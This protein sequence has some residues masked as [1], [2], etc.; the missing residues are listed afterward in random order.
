MRDPLLPIVTAWQNKIKLALESKAKRFGK[1]AE[2]GMK[3]FSGPCDWLYGESKGRHFK[4]TFDGDEDGEIPPPSFQMTVNK[5]AELVQ[6]FGPVLYHRNPVRQVNP[7]QHPGPPASLMQQ[8]MQDPMMALQFQ[9]LAAQAQASRAVDEARADLLEHY[10]NYTPTALD[11]KTHARMAIDEALIKGMGT[12]WTEVYQPPGSG[13]RMVGNFYDTVDNLV[14]DP[15]MP[16]LDTCKWIA[17]RRVQPCWEVERRFN[18]PA[19]SIRG[20]YESSGQQGDVGANDGGD[21]MRKTGQ[22]CDLCTY[23][24]VF[25][26]CGIGGRLSGVDPSIKN[27]LEAYGDFCYLAICEDCTYPLNL[28]DAVW[29][30]E[31]SAARSEIMK[32]VAW[33]TPF[34]ADGRWPMVPIYFHTIPGDPWPMSHLAPGLGELKFLNWAYSYV[35]G[36]IRISC[37]DFIAILQEAGAEVVESVQHGADYEII[38]IKGSNGRQI[39]EI[40][41][42]LQHP[43]F[44]ADI[45]KVI[46]AISE[47]F[48]RRVGLTE[49]MYGEAARQLRSASEAQLKR[50]AMS[51]RPDEM[52]SKV[53]DAMSL[54]ARMEALAARW[55]LSAKDVG[56]CLGPVGMFLWNM[57]ITPSDPAQVLFQLEYRVEANSAKKPNK[58]REAANA[59]Q[60]G[61]MLM[62]FFQQLAGSGLVGPFNALLAFISKT[63]EMDPKGLLLPTPQPMPAAQPQPQ[64]NPQPSPQ[65][66]Q[67]A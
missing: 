47:Q 46:E 2:E 65:A 33:P 62:P 28:P 20:K 44:N 45:W 53:E 43:Q 39:A 66:Q 35:A 25:S 37:R 55:H 10:L 26:K 64:P 50:D 51:V 8:A 36:K 12:L 31:E 52:A 61:Q 67:A 42:F 48:D 29:D 11:L 38:K 41:Q 14:V 27:E 5:T 21:Y 59:Q 3:F 1:D 32:R 57:F 19:G 30:M 49:L 24:E 17:R 22:T 7:R 60:M 34:W 16:T 15:D 63:I 18:L 54:A 58:D 6:I 9:T 4:Q 13:A 56:P 23:W 40:V